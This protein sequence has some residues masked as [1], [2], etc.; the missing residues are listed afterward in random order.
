MRTVVEH[1]T[2]SFVLESSAELPLQLEV[3]TEGQPNR[4]RSNIVFVCPPLTADSRVTNWWQ[5]LFGVGRYFDPARYAIVCAAPFGSA[6]GSTG[7]CTPDAQGKVLGHSF[8]EF[9]VRDVARANLQLLNFLGYHHISLLV[10]ASF[11]GAVALEMSIMNNSLADRLLLIACAAEQSQYRAAHNETQRMM[12]ELDP[13]WHDCG[14]SLNSQGLAIARASAVLS[15]R[16]STAYER[17]QHGRDVGTGRHVSV[18]YQHYKGHE[19]AARFNPISYHRLLTAHDTHDVGRDREGVS[20][21]L[22]RVNAR[23]NVIA[24]SGDQ[25]YPVSEQRELANGIGG[26]TLSVI[27]TDFG[28]DAFLIESGQ[29][30]D[31]LNRNRI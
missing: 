26:A 13:K 29:L 10:G 4:H 8:P 1:I 16:P 17:T 27:E 19:L 22:G 7:P 28:H 12:L 3:S 24:L 14:C 18:S 25:L 23:T 20:S 21:A 30:A 5:R 15:Y 2:H 9:T 6:Y 11:G 31:V